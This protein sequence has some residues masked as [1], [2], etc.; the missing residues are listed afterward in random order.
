MR[1]VGSA[2]GAV[3]VRVM[4]VGSESGAWGL[5]LVK[6]AEASAVARARTKMVE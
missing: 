5:R 3:E 6:V 2:V 1:V 4:M